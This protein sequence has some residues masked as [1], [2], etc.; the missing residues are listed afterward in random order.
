[1]CT[2][3]GVIQSISLLK[4]FAKNV[5]EKDGSGTVLFELCC[6]YSFGLNGTVWFGLNGMVW[7]GLNGMV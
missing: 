3:V 7:F 6:G 2:A 5:K 4:L 1:M